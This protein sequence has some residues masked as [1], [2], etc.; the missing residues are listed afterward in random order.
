MRRHLPRVARAR[1]E[2]WRR[3]QRA[4][5]DP[6]RLHGQAVAQILLQRTPRR[7]ATM[8]VPGHLRHPVGHV[9][10]QQHATLRLRRCDP[11][12]LS[13]SVSASFRRLH[14]RRDSPPIPLSPP[15][16]LLTGRRSMQRAN[17]LRDPLRALLEEEEQRRRGVQPSRRDPPPA[18]ST[19]SGRRQTTSRTWKPSTISTTSRVSRSRSRIA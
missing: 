16:R 3:G 14:T 12:A 2:R 7:G 19:S 1:L 13:L 8:R 11:R 6:R 5:P 15:P 9:P 10:A 18:S 4:R 17:V